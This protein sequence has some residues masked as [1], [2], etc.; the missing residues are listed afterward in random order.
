MHITELVWDEDT[1]LHIQ[2]N[3]HVTPEE[4]EDVCFSEN[5]PLIEVGR[6]GSQYITF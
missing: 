1:V 5:S 2:K 6:G 3:H 4:V